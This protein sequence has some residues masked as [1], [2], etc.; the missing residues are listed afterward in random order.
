M[1][2]TIARDLMRYHWRMKYMQEM[3]RV[4]TPNKRFFDEAKELHGRLLE[5]LKHHSVRRLV[6]LFLRMSETC[7][8]KLL[9][10]PQQDAP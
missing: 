2:E 6:P 9:S 7:D 1:P 3:K 4:S 8:K 5:R 10:P